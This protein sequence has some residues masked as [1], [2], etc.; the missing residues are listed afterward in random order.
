MAAPSRTLKLSILGDVSNLVSSLK[1]GE[2]ATDD[3]TKT[4]TDFGKKAAV[5]F[6]VAATAATAFAVSAVKNALADESAQRKLAETLR[7]STTATEAQI[8]AVSDWIDTTSV[9]IGVTDDQLRPA[10]SRLVRST[11]DVQKAQELVNLAL[12]ISVAT[13]KPLE[14]V[15][16]ALGKAYDGNA[17][18]LG[19]LGLGLDATILKGGDTDA[20]FQNLTTT[21]GNFAENEALTTEAQFR[22]VGI[23]V[24]EAKE[25]IG[26][27]LLPVVERLATFLITTVVPNMQTFIAS[28]TGTGSLAEATADGTLGAFEFGK[29]VEKVIKTVYNF[30][31][32]LIA[33]A[34]VIAGVFVV[35]KVAAGVTATIILI[36]SLIKAYNALKSSALVA[37]VALAFALNPLL[38]VG[39][40]AVAASVLAGANALANR[41][42][43]T[44]ANLGVPSNIVTDYGTY[45]P[46][47]FKADQYKGESFMGTMPK[48]GASSAA[49]REILGA[50][51]AE[52][53]TRRLEQISK[54]MSELTFRMTTGGISDTTAQAELKALKAEMAVLTKQSQALTTQPPINITV[55]GAIDKEGTARTVVDLL[56]NSYYRG[57]G[58]GANALVLP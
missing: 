34:A 27:A 43:A 21:F 19:R 24:D 26:A 53:L 40:V 20:I 51:S 23:A 15:S 56:N 13:G 28:L 58:A 9:A 47:E 25:S 55:N 37:G 44:T 38:G 22:R 35:S 5:A 30:R 32:V 6:T 3:Y 33:T 10:F 2:K 46:P 18:S 11:N 54:D 48:P 14:A 49:K 12:D 52:E 4:L 36:Q 29:M 1:T 17:T 7:A 45:V 50:G 41:D 42:N 16:N 39:A 31:G 57:G 8:S